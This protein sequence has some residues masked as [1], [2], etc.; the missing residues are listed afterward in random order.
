M[1]APD[2]HHLTAAQGWLELG[3][4]EEAFAELE[5]IQPQHRTHPDVLKLRW[6]IYAKAEKWG[7]AFAVA[8]G[9]ARLLPDDVEPFIWR[10]YSARRMQGGGVLHAFELLHAVVRDFPDEP[11]VPFNLACYCCRLGRMP[12]AQSWLHIAFEIAQ[13]NG[14][15]KHWKT[16]ALEESDL[17]TLRKEFK[18]C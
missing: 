1:T 8:Q 14:T 18:L 11:V 13:R 10:S 3:L 4:V 5:S 6:Q 7:H 9:L 16:K 15:E 12:Q 2:L 17:E